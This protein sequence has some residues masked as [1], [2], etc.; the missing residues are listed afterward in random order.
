M[1]CHHFSKSCGKRYCSRR[2]IMFLFSHVIKKD[3]MIKGSDDY[4]D[5]SPSRQFTTLPSLAV[6]GT[7]V[8]QI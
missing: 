2:D 6:T 8:V 1:V 5:R 7:V 4:N 3:P